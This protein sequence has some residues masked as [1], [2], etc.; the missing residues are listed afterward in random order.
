MLDDEWLPERR[1]LG[2]RIRAA[3]ID[4]DLTQEQLLLTAGVSR[5]VYQE[6]ESGQGNPRLTTLLRLASALNMHVADLLH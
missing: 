4:R 3:R 2:D 5:S 6:I 1:A